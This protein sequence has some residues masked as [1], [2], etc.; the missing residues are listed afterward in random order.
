MSLDGISGILD[1]ATNLGKSVGNTVSEYGSASG[2]SGILNSV[3]GAFSSLSKFFKKLEGVKLPLHNPLHTYASYDY[4][5]SFAC[6]SVNEVSNPDKTYMKGAPLTLICKSGNADP[7]NRINTAY[8]K[9]DFFFQNLVFDVATQ[10]DINMT[11]NY[12]IDFNII[13]PYSMGMFFEALEAAAER[14]GYATWRSAV[15][16]IAIEFRGNTETGSMVPVP[17]TKRYIPLEIRDIQM[18]VDDRG[19][20]YDISG[21]PSNMLA[22]ADNAAM[23]NTDISADGATVAEA[24]QSGELSLQVALNKFEKEKVAK[25]IQEK[26]NQYL[27]YFP[28][29][30]SSYPEAGAVTA[31]ESV[32]SAVIDPGTAG[33]TSDAIKTKFQ[34]ETSNITND[35]AQQL[36]N[37]ND[38]GIAELGNDPTREGD[39]PAVKDS[40]TYDRDSGTFFGGALGTRDPSLGNF[41]FDQK[42][43]IQNAINQVI[44]QSNYVKTKLDPSAL[45]ENGYRDW[46]SIRT[47]V[48]PLS[49][50]KDSVTGD[51]PRLYVYK[52]VPYKAHASRLKAQS[53][54]IPGIKLLSQQAVKQYN[55]IYTGKNDDI[56]AIN[57]DV[58]RSFFNIMPADGNT[59]NADSKTNERQGSGSEGGSTKPI[60]IGLGGS[61][62]NTKGTPSFVNFVGSLFKS[63][64]HGGGGTERPAT[65]AARAFMDAIAS[66]KD[67]YNITMTIMGDPYYIAHSGTGNYTASATQFINLN[68]DYTMAYENGEVDIVINFRTPIDLNQGTG[69]YSFSGGTKSSPMIRFSGL[70]CVTNVSNHFQD[71]K[72]IQYISAMRR[73]D[74]E[75]NA[76]GAAIA[77]AEEKAKYLASTPTEN[78]T[79]PKASEE[80]T[81]GDE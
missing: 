6:L 59:E 20:R 47:Q 29:D 76:V 7:S 70:Y 22:L 57:I 14:L 34:L 81:S 71:G 37:L 72:F 33:G 42:T 77:T 74:Q 5:L 21:I 78:K 13:E 12:K 51:I 66:D 16:L 53:Q 30:P 80:E 46:W 69:L 35:L 79:N 68:S 54:A 44:I 4:V 67:V 61:T 62:T 3:T 15:W 11:G 56:L 49:S 63:D 45:D 58:N 60:T 43:T 1:S 32:I 36:G 73:N 10:I 2:L 9:F 41:K 48:Y 31:V 23:F 39:S 65:R 27:I 52:V 24:L 25:G 26:A 18:H 50:T 38:I 8:G 55:Y 75:S 64:G 40:L 17:N 28:I 19:C